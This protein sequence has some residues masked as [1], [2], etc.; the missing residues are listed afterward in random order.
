MSIHKAIPKKKRLLVYEKYNHHC[1]YCGCDLEYKDMQVD[2]I[3]SVYKHTDYKQDMT[4]SEM[5]DIQNLMPSCRACNYYKGSSSIEIFR[6]KL[7]NTLI[8]NLR[9]SF[10]YRLALKYGLI[11]EN[12]KPIKFYFEKV[13]CMEQLLSEYTP[14]IEEMKAMMNG[15]ADKEQKD[16]GFFDEI[17]DDSED[18]EVY[19]KIK[20][21]ID[22]VKE[23]E[24]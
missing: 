22:K 4:W 24:T 8:S 7:S 23:Q 18:G 2:H 10:D 6:K 9:K 20:E 1:A 5:N 3:E 15:E 19:E 14:M 12:I 17:M 21:I 13:K 11:K 16:N